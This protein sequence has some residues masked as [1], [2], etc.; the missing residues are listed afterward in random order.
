MNT[1]PACQN[2]PPK[3]SIHSTAS[4]ESVYSLQLKLAEQR[5]VNQTMT[6]FLEET[7]ALQAEAKRADAE[8]KRAEAEKLEQVKR[9]MN[10]KV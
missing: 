6:E 3:S 5:Q 1:V 9:A 7:Y 8:A 2:S 4:G 10:A